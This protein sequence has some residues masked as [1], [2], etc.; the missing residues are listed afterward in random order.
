[1]LE[2]E[3]GD[4]S[5]LSTLFAHNTWANLKMLDFC[6]KLSELPGKARQRNRKQK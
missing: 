1:M 6:E 4:T 3:R 2:N 5:V